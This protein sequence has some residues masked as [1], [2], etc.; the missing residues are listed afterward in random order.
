MSTGTKLSHR[1]SNRANFIS[2]INEDKTLRLEA[3]TGSLSGKEALPAQDG[4]FFSTCTNW[5]KSNSAI[6]IN[7]IQIVYE[8][9]MYDSIA[10]I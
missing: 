2:Q 5:Y 3:T 6:F 9:I 7:L 1:W 8:Y 10:N 4:S